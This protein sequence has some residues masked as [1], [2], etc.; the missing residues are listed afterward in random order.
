[1]LTQKL[2]TV[3]KRNMIF[4]LY[5]LLLKQFYKK[6]KKQKQYIIDLNSI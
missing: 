6:K 1:M 5:S 3:F 4:L 2:L